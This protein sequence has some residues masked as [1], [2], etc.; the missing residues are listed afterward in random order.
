MEEKLCSLIGN[1]VLIVA[2][3]KGTAYI[4]KFTAI[5][6]SYEQCEV[7][8]LV[9]FKKIDENGS[10]IGEVVYFLDEVVNWQLIK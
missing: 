1:K 9:C 6:S 3:R 2:K 4:S 10:N 8:T 5:V 7:G